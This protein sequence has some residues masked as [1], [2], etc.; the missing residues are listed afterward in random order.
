MHTRDR[1]N[2]LLVFKVISLITCGVPSLVSSGQQLTCF[3]CSPV[4]E[5]GESKTPAITQRWLEWG[6]SFCRLASGEQSVAGVYEHEKGWK[7]YLCCIISICFNWP[8]SAN[9]LVNC[10]NW[11]RCFLKQHLN[12]T[13]TVFILFSFT[14]Y[15]QFLTW[16][17]GLYNNLCD[18]I[19]ANTDH[20]IWWDPAADHMS[21]PLVNLILFASTPVSQLQLTWWIS[22]DTRS[23]TLIKFLP[24]P[25]SSHPK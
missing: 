25:I 24:F 12:Y 5:G 13:H 18:L 22:A 15:L 19:P 14:I 21:L 4:A 1:N 17:Q 9:K 20:K 3:N 2:L 6:S 16:T 23:S 7:V 8:N 10:T 11:W